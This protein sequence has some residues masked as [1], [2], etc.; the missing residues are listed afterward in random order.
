MKCWGSNTDGQLGAASQISSYVA[1]E[2][3]LAAEQFTSISAGRSFSCGIVYPK[4]L[5]CWGAD[6]IGIDPDNY[7][8]SPVP[9]QVDPNESYIQVS[10]GFNH[11]CAITEN[12]H[13]KCW[14]NNGYNQ[15]GNNADGGV[16]VPT[17]IDTS[18]TYLQVSSN[19]WHSCGVTTKNKIKCWGRDFSAIGHTGTGEIP[20]FIDSSDSFKSVSSGYTHGCG[21]TTNNDLKCW[22][23]NGFKELG[24][25]NSSI[26]E[27]F[28]P[29]HIDPGVKYKSVAAGYVHT[30]AITTANKLKC[31]GGDN[32]GVLGDDIPEVA[33]D[34]PVAIDSA[35]NYIYIS[36]KETHSCGMTDQLQ[37]KCWGS[38]TSSQLGYV[39][40]NDDERKT[41]HLVNF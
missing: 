27:L 6:F 13:L 35:T 28:T 33:R 23:D 41:P 15:L 21:I 39:P 25:G 1:P 5:Y 40:N 22:G 12:Y 7:S 32:Q 34:L 9:V 29:A 14:G 17:R 38:N 20:K 31:W 3:V 36:I 24:V 30:C 37:V 19:L 16:L 4:K 10:V 26:V 8:S 2:A 18:E 11:A